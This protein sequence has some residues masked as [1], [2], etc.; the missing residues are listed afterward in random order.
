MYT[1]IVFDYL[2]KSK[3]SQRCNHQTNKL[4]LAVNFERH[5]FA[6]IPPAICLKP[7]GAGMIRVSVIEPR[8][9]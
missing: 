1:I 8:G 3:P 5:I 9:T 4:G 6:V 2:S 7:A